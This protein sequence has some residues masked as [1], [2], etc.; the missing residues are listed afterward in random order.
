[1]TRR[2]WW[3]LSTGSHAR[4]VKLHNVGETERSLKAHFSEH[5]RPSS[6][7]S[8]VSKHTHKDNPDH[9]VEMDKTEILSFAIWTELV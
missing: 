1:M 5:H 2:R 9:S 3:G 4:T 6:V 8:K 7:N